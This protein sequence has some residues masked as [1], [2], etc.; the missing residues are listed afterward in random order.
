MSG[1]VS[2]IGELSGEF[3]KDV[4]NVIYDEQEPIEDQIDLL[5]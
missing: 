1:H 3:Y 2:A 4:N 5:F